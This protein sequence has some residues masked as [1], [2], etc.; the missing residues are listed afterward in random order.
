MGSRP[1][2]IRPDPAPSLVEPIWDTGQAARYLQVHPRTITRM[3]KRGG[4]PA[5]H[6]G[7][8]WR[9]RK[10]DLDAWLES[11]VSPSRNRVL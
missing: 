7:R 3:A 9:F 1:E 5:I 10:S 6:L 8:L 11:R 4:I 2:A